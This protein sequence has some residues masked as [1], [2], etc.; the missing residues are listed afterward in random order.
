MV[1]STSADS[2]SYADRFENQFV[3]IAEDRYVL[4]DLEH[5]MAVLWFTSP[6]RGH[7]RPPESCG[8]PRK[9]EVEA[10]IVESAG[11]VLSRKK[12][13]NS[14]CVEDAWIT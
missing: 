7:K 6:T 1:K 14:G 3:V 10:L 9:S 2:S 13:P 11:T 8:G 4:P 5:S 12:K